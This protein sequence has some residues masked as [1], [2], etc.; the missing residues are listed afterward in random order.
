MSAEELDAIA[1]RAD[2]LDG[3]PVDDAAQALPATTPEPVVSP[4]VQAVGFILSVFV[5]MSTK[6]LKVES[7]QRTLSDANIATIADA[8]APVADKYGINLAGMFDGPEG[9]ALLVAGPLLW[10]AAVELKAELAARR[11]DDGV[12]RATPPSDPQGG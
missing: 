8:V 4:N 6:L 9:K 7:L 11:A 1:N 3:P 2:V 12:P 10:T 5:L